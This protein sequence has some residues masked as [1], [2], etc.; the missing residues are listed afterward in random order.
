MPIGDNYISSSPCVVNFLFALVFS[1]CGYLHD[2]V[3][4]CVLE[5]LAV[6]VCALVEEKSVMASIGSVVGSSPIGMIS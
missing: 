3:Y 6:S 4:F 1:I 5:V 2:V